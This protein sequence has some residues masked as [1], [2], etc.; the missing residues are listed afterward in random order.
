MRLGPDG[1]IRWKVQ[2]G[3]PGNDNGIGAAAGADGNVFLTGYTDGLM[4]ATLSGLPASVQ[5]NQPA[6]GEDLFIAK[7]SAALGTIQSIHPT[8]P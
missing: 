3:G 2:F 4:P 1:S 6:G 8:T 5:L 7:L